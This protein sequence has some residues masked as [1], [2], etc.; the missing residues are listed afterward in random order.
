MSV[1]E[2]RGGSLGG[3]SEDG[4]EKGSSAAYALFQGRPDFASAIRDARRECVGSSLAVVC[5]GPPRLA[6][7][8]RRGVVEVLGEKDGPGVEFFN[9]A[10][11][12]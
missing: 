3:G 1:Y 7:A 8:C 9:E 10:M 4:G 12:W 6:D 2:T 5:C 11:A